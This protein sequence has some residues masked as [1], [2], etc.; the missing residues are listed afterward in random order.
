MSGVAVDADQTDWVVLLVGED[1]RDV[2]VVA[3]DLLHFPHDYVG[4]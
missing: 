3:F 1:M 4:L 2:G